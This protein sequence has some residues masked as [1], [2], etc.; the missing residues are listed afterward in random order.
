[1]RVQ[2]KHMIQL[3]LHCVY[4]TN[5]LKN[6]IPNFTRH[7]SI[8]NIS[9]TNVKVNNISNFVESSKSQTQNLP[10]L[11]KYYNQYYTSALHAQA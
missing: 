7:S 4:F 1:M 5:I 3:S 11:L 6:D 9:N 2:I 10:K 8:N